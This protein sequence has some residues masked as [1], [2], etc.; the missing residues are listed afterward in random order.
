MEE[1]NCIIFFVQTFRSEARQPLFGISD[2]FMTEHTGGGGLFGV[3]VED[4]NGC[5]VDKKSNLNF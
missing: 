4:D 1:F 2:V 3:E 5:L